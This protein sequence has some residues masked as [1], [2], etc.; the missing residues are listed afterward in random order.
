MRGLFIGVMSGPIRC[1]LSKATE[2]KI[3]VSM[4][5]GDGNGK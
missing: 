3:A 1:D 2:G 5:V 4:F